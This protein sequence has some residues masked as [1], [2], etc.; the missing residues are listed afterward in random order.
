MDNTPDSQNPAR[1]VTTGTAAA[2]RKAA[3][4]HPLRVAEAPTDQENR[5]EDREAAHAWLATYVPKDV[6]ARTWG[7]IRDFVVE[8]VERLLEEHDI[9]HGAVRRTYIRSLIM[10]A[11]YCRGHAPS[12]AG[13]DRAGPVHGQPVRGRDQEVRARERGDLPEPPALPRRAA[14]ARPALGA[15]RARGTPGRL[16][17]PTRSPNW[18]CCGHG[19]P[20]TLPLDAAAAKG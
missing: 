3:K 19:S 2:A 12:P 9:T 13:R 18:R 11:C 14:Q 8:C 20:T 5:R 1:V 6:D 17:S 15:A 10:L 7:A 4:T 16:Q